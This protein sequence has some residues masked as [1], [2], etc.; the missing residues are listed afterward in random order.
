MT[1]WADVF[2]VVSLLS[3]PLTGA[4]ESRTFFGPDRPRFLPNRVRTPLGLALLALL[5]VGFRY[6]DYPRPEDTDWKWVDVI[7][8][9][10][11]AFSRV[12]GI[13]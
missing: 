1:I 11:T 12:F 2:I 3:L 13:G 4:A 10:G 7:G 6:Q 9:I 5:F 8:Q